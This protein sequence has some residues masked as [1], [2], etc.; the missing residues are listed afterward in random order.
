MLETRWGESD[1]GFYPVDLTLRAFDRGGLIRDITSIIADENANVV[2]LRS[3]TDKKSMQVIMDLSVEIKD[4]PTLS[5]TISRLE[6]L[7]N[8]VSVRRKA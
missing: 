5:T 3:R 2:E 4:L 7:P 6:Q 1:S 8:V